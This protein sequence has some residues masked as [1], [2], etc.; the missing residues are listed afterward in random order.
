GFDTLTMPV[1]ADLCAE[2]YDSER[3]RP[4]PASVLDRLD[5][6]GIAVWYGDDGTFAGSY[7]RWGKGK[8]ALYNKSL[9]GEARA[10]VMATFERLGIGRPRDDGRG[11]WFNSDQ[12]AALHALIAPF[13]HPAVDYK[14]HPSRRGRF[15]WHPVEAAE[16]DLAER[17][18]L[19]AVP[20]RIV[21]RYVKP[22]TRGMNRFDLE[23]E[24]N[25]TYLADGVVVHN[26]PET[27]SGG[28]A[29][30]FYAS[31][32]M[33]VRRTE[34]I[35]QGTESV[36]V[37]TKVKV[38][39][40][41]LAPPFREAEFDVIYGEGISKA[42]TVLDAGVEQGL[43]EKSGTWYTYKNERIGQGR[44]NAK[45][46]LQENQT[47]L[48]DLETKIREALNLRAPASLK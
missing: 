17:R 26:S 41:K 38:V 3:R 8:A 5:A 4:A 2:V 16:T 33:D 43:I 25:H 13:V 21:K 15:A 18:V 11:F 27:T 10:R 1:L 19:R 20:A 47:T 23:V 14:L 6:R 24:G 28:R 12:T 46:W 48:I 45:K 40:N 32:R 35:K 34:T 7:A 39:K 9:T 22:Q 44:E 31:I 29:L 30:K 36:G 37:R 42:A